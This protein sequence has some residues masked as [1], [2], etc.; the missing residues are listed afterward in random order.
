[1]WGGRY[2][3]IIPVDDRETAEALVKLFRVDDLVRMSS[4]SVVV[5]FIAAHNHLASPIMGG[6][7]FVPTMPS[8][9]ALAVVD[10]GHPAIR[11]YEQFFRN[12]P[13]PP[14]G[15]RFVPMGGRRSA[16]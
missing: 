16:R 8:G 6:E 13:K 10:I 11:L 15:A 5:D 14:T 9:K 12:N 1:M 7:L 4:D 2:N 3:P